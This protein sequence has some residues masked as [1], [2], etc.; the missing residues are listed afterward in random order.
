M[1][2][3]VADLLSFDSSP[4]DASYSHLEHGEKIGAQVTANE[5]REI[6]RVCW[7][8][9]PGSLAE[10]FLDGFLDTAK[11]ECPVGVFLECLDDSREVS[12]APLIVGFLK[13]RF[14]LST[15]EIIDHCLARLDLSG[16]AGAQDRL[17][18]AILAA[19]TLASDQRTRLSMFLQT[20]TVS[21]YAE[22][23]LREALRR[24]EA[25]AGGVRT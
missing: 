6:V 19:G 10:S 3:L 14:R 9:L 13:G 16:D 21:E 1:K 8:A 12:S 22:E 18:Y 5:A 20:R 25:A 15:S 11:M 2:S 7:Q 17:A 23:C 24:S 4:P